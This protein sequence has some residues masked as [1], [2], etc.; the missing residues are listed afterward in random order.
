MGIQ[1]EEFQCEASVQD[2]V[3][4]P[5]AWMVRPCEWYWDEF[6]EC[7]RIRSRIHQYFIY[8]RTQDCSQWNRDY[9]NCIS[10]RKK[11]DVDSLNSL[12]ASEE[13]RVKKRMSNSI[14]NDV[15][16]YR[17]SPPTNWS[18]PLPEWMEERMKGTP[19]EY[20]SKQQRHDPNTK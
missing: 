7:S 19:L 3:N 8:G 11:K 17:S 18:D 1:G 14:R 10:F 9:N 20:Y 5:K 13:K 2:Q 16:S 6:K 4:Y 12:I 15:W